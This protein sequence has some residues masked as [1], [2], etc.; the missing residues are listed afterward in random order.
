[1]HRNRA[2]HGKGGGGMC[3]LNMHSFAACH[4]LRVDNPASLVDGATLESATGRLQ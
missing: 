3:M 4:T 1:M 2:E